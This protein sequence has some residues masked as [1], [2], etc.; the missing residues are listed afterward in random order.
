MDQIADVAN[1][2]DAMFFIGNRETSNVTNIVLGDEYGPCAG[3][4][5]SACNELVKAGNYGA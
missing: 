4:P 1:E 2:S 5:L 3:F